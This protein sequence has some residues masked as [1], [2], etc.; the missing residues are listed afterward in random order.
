MT[1]VTDDRRELT[2]LERREET[3]GLL[4]C[5]TLVRFFPLLVYVTVLDRERETVGVA[6]MTL[7]PNVWLRGVEGGTTTSFDLP[8]AFFLSSWNQV[9]T[10][11]RKLARWPRFLA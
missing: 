5:R 4:S 1:E 2:L 6:T 11:L 3:E 8:F 7:L 9:R 10:A